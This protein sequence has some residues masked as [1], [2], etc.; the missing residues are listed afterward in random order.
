MAT[1][2]RSKSQVIRGFLPGQ[3]F[4]HANDTIV[5]VSNLYAGP[6]DVNTELLVEM[7]DERL[8][9]WQRSGE[10]AARRSIARLATSS[11]SPTTSTSTPSWS[12]RARF[13]TTPGR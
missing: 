5:R 2:T 7:L 4:Q 13:S 3:T 10:T 8:N 11:R 12:L 1:M 6:A 9:H